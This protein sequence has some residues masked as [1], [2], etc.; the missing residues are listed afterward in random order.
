MM[1]RGGSICMKL[2]GRCRG[3]IHPTSFHK[4][5][6]HL[7][8]RSFADTKIN[9]T[10]DEKKSFALKTIFKKYGYVAVGTYLSVY[11]MTLCSVFVALDLDLLQ[12]STF[13]FDPITTTKNACDKIEYYTGIKS[14]PEFIRQ[15]P[16]AGTFA[17]AWIMTKFTEPI[18]LGA[19]MAIVPKLGQYVYNKK[20]PDKSV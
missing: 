8:I 18:R 10:R 3:G 13:G 9:E 16:R 4:I 2:S 7:G 15:N 6:F 1:L 20:H 12:S 17:I 11:V 5:P 14:V 19:T